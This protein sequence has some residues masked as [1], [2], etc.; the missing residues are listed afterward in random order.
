MVCYTLSRCKILGIVLQAL[1]IARF[2]EMPP[3]PGGIFLRAL[4]LPSPDGTA[5]AD[6]LRLS[7]TDRP[8]DASCTADDIS[9]LN[10]RSRRRGRSQA[11]LP[12]SNRH[13]SARVGQQQVAV[14]RDG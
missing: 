1:I 7:M 10:G 14:A 5:R 11:P 6:R 13:L 9:A 3:I 12:A 2:A 8:R 4:G